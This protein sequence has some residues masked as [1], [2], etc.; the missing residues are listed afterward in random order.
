MAA[1]MSVWRFQVRRALPRKVSAMGLILSL[2]LTFFA[3]VQDSSSS[4]VPPLRS[5]RVRACKPKYLVETET[6]GSIDE[7]EK[8]VADELF[9]GIEE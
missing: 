9:A 4:D 1:L 7:M 2:V 6:E 3:G 5:P 8:P